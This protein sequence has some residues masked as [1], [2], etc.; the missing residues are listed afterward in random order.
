[1]IIIM[2]MVLMRVG[3]RMRKRVRKKWRIKN[4][5]GNRKKIMERNYGIEIIRNARK[6]RMRNKRNVD[7]FTRFQKEQK[8]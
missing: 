4:L 8:N 5:I 7:L 1:M 6:E 2:M 3:K